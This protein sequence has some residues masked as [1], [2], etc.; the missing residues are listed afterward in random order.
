MN[1]KNGEV[2]LPP[3]LLEQLQEYVQGD[4]IYIPK[5]QKQ[6]I[7]WG[8]NCGT[9]QLI[10]NRNYE[11]YQLYK[12]GTKIHEIALEYYLS[13]DSIRKIVRTIA[14]TSV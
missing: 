11:I 14:R 10:K 4:I 9:K 2:L 12:N 13:E 1:Y 7:G 5:K 8:E 3:E 6:R